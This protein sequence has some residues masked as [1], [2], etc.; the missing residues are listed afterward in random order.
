MISKSFAV[1]K[2]SLEDVQTFIIQWNESQEVPLKI[3]TRLAICSDEIASNVVFYS[4]ASNLEI[5]CEIDDGDISLRFIDDGKPFDP[6]TEAG[7][8][9]INASIENREIGGLGIFMVKKMMDSVQYQRTNDKNVLV[10][11]ISVT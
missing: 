4:G 1:K 10:I 8:P 11:R 2:E 6:L 3:S 7:E 9:D 5:E